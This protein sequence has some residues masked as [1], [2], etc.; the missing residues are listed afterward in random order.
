VEGHR[1]RRVKYHTRAGAPAA[2]DKVVQLHH[3]AFWVQLNFFVFNNFLNETKFPQ[4]QK[5]SKILAF[6]IKV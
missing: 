6:S 4:R 1:E 5:M 3:L 2:Q